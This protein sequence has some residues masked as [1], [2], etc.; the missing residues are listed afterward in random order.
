M[1]ALGFKLGQ[2]GKRKPLHSGRLFLLPVYALKPVSNVRGVASSRRWPSCSPMKLCS[3]TVSEVVVSQND[4][5]A[6]TAKITDFSHARISGDDTIHGFAGAL[7]TK[8]IGIGRSGSGER[9]RSRAVIV[10]IGDNLAGGPAGHVA[11]G[12]EIDFAPRYWS[13]S[14]IARRNARSP[15]LFS[16]FS[17]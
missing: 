10:I 2:F 11:I 8:P 1:K 3:L 4:L 14:S 17:V 15:R 12:V 16:L 13:N 6:G 9:N 5:F 7:R